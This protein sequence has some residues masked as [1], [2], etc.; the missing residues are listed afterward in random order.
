MVEIHGGGFIVGN[1]RMTSEG[2]IRNYVSTGIVV[3]SIQYRLGFLGEYFK[4][5]FEYF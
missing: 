1:G 5:N 2:I 4:E 3:V